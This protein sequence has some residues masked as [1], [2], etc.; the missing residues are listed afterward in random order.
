MKKYNLHTIMTR[1][2]EIVRKAGATISQALKF[3][4]KI[5]KKEV[6]LREEYDAFDDDDIVKF[7]IWARYGYIRAYYTRSW[8]SNYENRKKVNFVE[9]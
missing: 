9:M 3:S 2:W 4:W 7:N 8:V 5:A 1:A 6:E